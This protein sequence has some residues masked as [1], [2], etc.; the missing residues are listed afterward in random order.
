[1]TTETTRETD[2]LSTEE[3]WSKAW[4]GVGD[5]ELEFDPRTPSF[6]DLHVV[7]GEN[8]PA[9][10]SRT[11]LEVGCYPGAYMWYFNRYHGYSISGLEYVDWCA[12]AVRRAFDQ[13]GVATSVYERD[14]FATDGLDEMPSYDVVFSNGFVE[15]FEDT[16]FVVR[17][18]A[19]YCKPGG[20]VVILLPNHSGVYGDIMKKVAPD[21][22]R[23]HNLMDGAQLF[24]AAN[25]VGLERIAEGY[26][27][28]LGFWNTCLYE[29]VYP[30][31]RL[32]YL[33]VRAPGWVLER[34]GRV[35]PNS[36]SLSP[37]I[38]YIGRVPEVGLNFD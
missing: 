31:G 10:E 3:D 38:Y 19:R 16:E 14:F 7:L 12:A 29:T 24:D 33:S 1:M 15:H 25:A 8:L 20:L 11:L 23:I 2:K 5:L 6:R 28:R 34:V 36:K 26:A 27:G 18:H 13:R 9:G 35:L 22:H 37:N 32:A 21:K 30:K 17:Q 4:S